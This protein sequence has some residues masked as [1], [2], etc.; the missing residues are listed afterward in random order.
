MIN[1]K[2]LSVLNFERQLT[3]AYLTCERLYPNYS[4]FSQQYNFGDPQLLR[5][6]IDLALKAI[7]DRRDD[8]ELINQN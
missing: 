2:K 8:I 5:E 1:I 4:Y 6:C 3:F 7:I